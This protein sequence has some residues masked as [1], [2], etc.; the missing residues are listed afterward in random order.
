MIGP[1]SGREIDRA[2][3]ER[4]GDAPRLLPALTS[5]RF[6]FAF[7]V[8]LFH[9]KFTLSAY[10]SGTVFDQL[11][12]G[13]Q[14]FFV[15]SGFVLGYSHRARTALPL[16]DFYVKRF[17]RIYP[18][19]VITG[20]FWCVFFLPIWDATPRQA[21]LS[22][23]ANVTLTQAFV[24]GLVFALG[25][26]A[27]SWSLSD[28]AFFYA[29]F[30]VVRRWKVALAVVIMVVAY[31]VTAHLLNKQGAIN[32]AFPLFNYFFPPVRLADFAV[33]ILAA[34]LFV[35]G[36]RLR[37]A[38]LLEFALVLG[39]AAQLRLLE[40]PP[41]FAQLGFLVTAPVFLWV[42]AHQQGAISRFLAGSRLLVLLGEASFSLY[43]WHM[44][45][46]ALAGRHLPKD[47]PRWPTLIGVVALVIVVAVLSFLYVERPCRRWLTSR[48]LA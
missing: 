7:G 10:V 17:A 9:L 34:Q 16:R 24:P 29:V 3:P 5:L 15:L 4:N 45:L 11:N 14:F 48:L 18:L 36:S 19:H 33:G 38:T 32:A 40:L 31:F 25:I 41:D 27:V 8:L 28:E 2:H 20:L 42:F 30:P 39:V 1:D 43:M 37:A 12:I 47:L 46:L 13:V 21:L 22:G 23:L 26:N 35:P 6:F 44:M